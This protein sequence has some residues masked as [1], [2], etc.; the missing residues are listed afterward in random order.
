MQVKVYRRIYYQRFM[1][2]LMGLAVVYLLFLFKG[3]MI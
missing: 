3:F 2:L 1:L